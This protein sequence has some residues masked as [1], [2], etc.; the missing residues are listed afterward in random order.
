MMAPGDS[1]YEPRVQLMTSTVTALDNVLARAEGLLKETQA[2][3]TALLMEREWLSHAQAAI[4][5]L[6][7][8]AIATGDGMPD[9]LSLVIEEQAR[10]LDELLAGLRHQ[11]E[12]E[13]EVDRDTRPA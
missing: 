3:H 5:L 2:E 10:T 8:Q 9:S 4:A 13:A 7:P 6:G 12:A 11:V 1:A